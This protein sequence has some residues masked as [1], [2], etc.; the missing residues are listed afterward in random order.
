M[1]E[2]NQKAVELIELLETSSEPLY[3]VER[4]PEMTGFAPVT[5]LAQKG[6]YLYHRT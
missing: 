1:M 2:N 5:S 6:G 4:P 3:H